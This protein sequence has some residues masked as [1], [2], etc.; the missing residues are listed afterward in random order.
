MIATNI[1][2][3]FFQLAFEN[4]IAEIVFI[5]F[6]KFIDLILDFKM[7]KVNRLLGK[8]GHKFI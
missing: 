5:Q 1:V 7:I 3:R 8:F 2:D 4:L 6:H